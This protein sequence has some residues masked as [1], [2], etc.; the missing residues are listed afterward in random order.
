KTEATL[1]TTKLLEEVRQ[2]IA[3]YGEEKLR[4]FDEWV[5]IFREG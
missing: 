4:M 5:R 1:T 2:S 3:R